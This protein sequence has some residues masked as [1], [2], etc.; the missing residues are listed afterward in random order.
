MTSDLQEKREALRLGK[1]GCRWDSCHNSK[2]A[3]N[4]RIRKCKWGT[5]LPSCLNILTDILKN[6]RI[7]FALHYDIFPFIMFQVS[8]ENR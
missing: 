7:N 2:G 8:A 5:P 4:M 3:E 1:N 6:I